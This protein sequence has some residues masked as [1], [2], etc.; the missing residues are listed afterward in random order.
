MTQRDAA[1][2]GCGKRELRMELQELRYFV[3]IAKDGSYTKAAAQLYVSQPALS[4]AMKKLEGELQVPLLDVRKN[5]V[6]LTDYGQLLYERSVRL[7]GE[8]DSLQGIVRDIKEGHTGSLKIGATPMLSNMFLEKI[9]VGFNKQFPDI[10]I[11]VTE[12]GNTQLRKMLM[13]G[14][15]DLMF[16]ID[17]TPQNTLEEHLLFTD[18][19]VVCVPED[20]PLAK[21]ERLNMDQLR[22]AAFNFYT[23]ASRL[24]RMTMELCRRS[25]Y[26]P[27]TNFCSSNVDSVMRL[28]AKG[29]GICFFPRSYA[30]FARVPGIHIIP[31]D[32]E[33]L[34]QPC[35]VKNTALY[36][37][38]ASKRFEEYTI[39]FF[40]ENGCDV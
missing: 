30:E 1:Q 37:S 24:H 20:N 18:K 10:R 3:Q 28:T 6:C 4:K 33:F 11:S 9:L 39:K 12:R 22:D 25:G 34:W 36:Q 26:E 31:L 29:R 7:I 2:K 38:V 17:D 27:N 16:G 8:F 21:K 40:E 13:E 35:L 15:L 32:E 19:M 5:T 23:P 14:D